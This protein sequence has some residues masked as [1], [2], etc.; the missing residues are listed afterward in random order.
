MDPVIVK[1]KELNPEIIAP[2]SDKM[3]EPEYGGSKIVVIGKPG[4]FTAG[5]QILM[6]NGNSKNVEDIKVNDV[7]MGDDS[8]PRTVLELC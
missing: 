4:C 6:Y 8:T 1:I 2:T 3:N 5:T 7:I